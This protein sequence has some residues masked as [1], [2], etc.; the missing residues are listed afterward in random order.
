VTEPETPLLVEYVPDPAL[1]KLAK[2]YRFEKLLSDGCGV[3]YV[4]SVGGLEAWLES[5]YRHQPSV[6]QLRRTVS[7]A[8]LEE[9]TFVD[10]VVKEGGA[11]LLE[12]DG[13]LTELASAAAGVMVGLHRRRRASGSKDGHGS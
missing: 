12:Q 8:M 3:V 6:E 1:R 5:L 2:R 10:Y 9:D 4:E 11:Q 7:A 13:K